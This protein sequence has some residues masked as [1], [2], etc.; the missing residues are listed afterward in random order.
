MELDYYVYG[1]NQNII[2]AIGNKKVHES[3]ANPKYER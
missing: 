3:L 1:L 2:V